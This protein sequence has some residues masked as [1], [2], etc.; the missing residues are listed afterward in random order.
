MFPLDRLGAVGRARLS[1]GDVGSASISLYRNHA[2]SV[3]WTKGAQVIGIAA[4]RP[5]SGPKSWEASHL[6]LKSDDES[7]AARLIEQL[8]AG[9]Q[10]RRG[11][12]LFLRMERRDRMVDV[13]TRI[14]FVIGAH[15]VL[16]LGRR[17]TTLTHSL[18]EVREKTPADDHDLFRLYNALTPSEVRFVTGMAFEQWAS[19]RDLG[20][21]PCREFVYLKEGQVR[22]WIN[23]SQR[24]GFGRIIIATHPNDDV[25]LVA[26]MDY[27]LSRL[28]GNR[29]QCLA[30]ENNVLLSRLLEQRGYGA[31]T[32]YVTL[33]RQFAVNVRSA[34]S[35]RVAVTVSS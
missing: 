13:A 26:L 30:D 8:C 32:E 20:R 10:R 31:Q 23:V 22:G 18:N 34:E 12:R 27:G 4:A 17:N 3:V 29:V 2:H 14:G 1:L 16:Y 15:E 6:F 25:G 35:N 9:V 19:S 24:F 28:R 7:G 33:V 5:R 11:E 21:G